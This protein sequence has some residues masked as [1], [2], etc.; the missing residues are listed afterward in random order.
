MQ[1]ELELFLMA[2]S[3]KSSLT[4]SPPKFLF[5]AQMYILVKNIFVLETNNIYIVV[6]YSTHPRR[7][8]YSIYLVIIVNNG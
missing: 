4:D 8:M 1:L 6:L 3:Q 5:R 7:R 2:V